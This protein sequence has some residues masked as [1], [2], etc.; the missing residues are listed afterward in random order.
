MSDPYRRLQKI[1]NATT[2]RITSTPQSKNLNHEL[3]KFAE[4]LARMTKRREIYGFDLKIWVES[5]SRRKTT[6]TTEA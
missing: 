6:I 5:H 4:I 2:F 3:K 1:A